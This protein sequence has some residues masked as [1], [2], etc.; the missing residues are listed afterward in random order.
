MEMI[1]ER[2]YSVALGFAIYSF[3]G[4]GIVMP[5][6]HACDNPEKFNYIFVAAMIT[7]TVIMVAFA[8]LCYFTWGSSLKEP[9]VTEMLPADSKIVVATKLLFSINLLAGFAIM[10]N[11]ANKIIESWIF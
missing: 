11:P 7:L 2:T 9:V 1:N 5:V 6:M 10:V 8:E 4:I 3:E